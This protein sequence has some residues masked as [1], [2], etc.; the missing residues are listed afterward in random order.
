MFLVKNKHG[1]CLVYIGV[2]C[3]SKIAS[4]NHRKILLQ[5]SR[6]QEENKRN[7]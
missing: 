5:A 4:E 1:K 3:G 6:V 2:V 7:I